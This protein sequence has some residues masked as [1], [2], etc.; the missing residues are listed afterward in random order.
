MSGSLLLSFFLGPAAGCR[1]SDAQTR[2]PLLLDAQA[3]HSSLRSN[4]AREFSGVVAVAQGDRLIF[5]DALGSRDRKQAVPHKASTRFAIASLTKQFTAA[6]VLQAVQDGTVDLNAPVGDYL[7]LSE[8]WA[9]KVTI[10]HLL[11]HTSGV[12]EEG[13]PPTFSP[14]ESFSYSNYGY[15]LLGRVLEQSAGKSFEELA[16]GLFQSCGMA[17]TSIL[18]PPAPPTMA[19]G[20]HEQ[21]DGQIR[22][23]AQEQEGLFDAAGGAVS[24]AADLVQWN[25][26]VHAG[27]ALS[28]PL[29]QKMTEP[30]ASREHRW[31]ELGYGYGVQLDSTDG[32]KEISHSGYIEGFISTLVF[33]PDHCVSL[34]VL[35]NIS[36]KTDDMERIFSHHDSLREIVR[37]QLQQ[38]EAGGCRHVRSQ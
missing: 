35:E 22:Q 13:E 14:G 11:S 33:Y 26:C 9:T 1:E 16:A 29:H 2:S 21:D 8:T 27:E 15:D 3:L 23:A 37:T 36:W 32:L 10:H 38:S 5:A 34:V 6:L 30:S 7:S 19:T 4:E 25:L 18:V 28:E 12:G 31:G 24:S 20:Y 17:S